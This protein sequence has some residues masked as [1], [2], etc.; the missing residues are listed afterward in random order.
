MP[1]TP[2]HLG[3]GMALKALAG[4]HLSFM[5][6]GG[7]QVLMDLEP[8]FGIIQGKAT[9]HGLSHTVAGAAVIGAAAAVSGK[10][11]STWALRTMN[12]PHSGL[13]WRCAWVSAYVGTFSHI[14]LDAVMHADMA[15]FWPFGARNPWLGIVDINT[16][17]GICAAAAGLGLC[18][19]G[20]RRARGLRG[21]KPLH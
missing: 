3:P 20:M 17:H 4:R 13:T 5:V 14:G 15:P 8:L 6:F 16:L 19:F 12:V 21:E 10:P 11:I 2:F 9:L 18:I 1:F 7:S